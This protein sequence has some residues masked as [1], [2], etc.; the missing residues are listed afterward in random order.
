[1]KYTVE[2]VAVRNKQREREK[3]RGREGERERER[4]GEREKWP[5]GSNID[6]SRWPPMTF[7]VRIT[8]FQLRSTVD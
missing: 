3:E 1:L 7:H 6:L 8:L 2:L 5:V 4:G